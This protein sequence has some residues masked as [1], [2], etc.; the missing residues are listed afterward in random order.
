MFNFSID[1]DFLV[2]Y[3]GDDFL[4]SSFSFIGDLSFGLNIEKKLSNIERFGFSSFG[5]SS[6]FYF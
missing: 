3:S 4:S 2:I 6:D 5:F 1:K